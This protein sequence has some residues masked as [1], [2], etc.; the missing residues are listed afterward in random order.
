MVHLFVEAVPDD[1][2]LP[3]G[4]R[5]LVADGGGDV[6]VVM[7]VPDECEDGSVGGEVGGAG[8]SAW[9]DGGGEGL[10]LEVV[11]EDVAGDGDAQA[12]DDPQEVDVVALAVLMGEPPDGQ[13]QGYSPSVTGKSAFPGHENLEETL[14]GAEIVVRLIEDA[15]TQTG[16]H[17]G[18]NQH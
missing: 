13:Q 17:D 9:E 4:K 8:E 10:G 16:S 12:V 18:G 14:P 5:W 7:D 3:D 11:G 6:S 1:T 2:A 15:V